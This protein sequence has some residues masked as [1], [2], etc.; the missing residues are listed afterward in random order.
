MEHQAAWAGVVT[1]HTMIKPGAL[2]RAR[3]GY[4]IIPARE[5][6]MNPFAWEGL[7]EP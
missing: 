4:L 3:G 2:H 6:P 5:C 7:K 1:D